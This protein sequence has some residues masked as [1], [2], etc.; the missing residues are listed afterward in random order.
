MNYDVFPRRNL[1]PEA[2]E[3]GRT[4]EDR[5]YQAE[6]RSATSDQSLSGL[7]RSSAA[8][9]ENLAEQINRVEALYRAI[10]KATQQT[11]VET[12]FAVPGTGTWNTIASVSFTYPEPGT[13]SLS[14]IASGQL[15]SPSTSTLMGCN[16]RIVATGLPPS[17]VAPGLYATPGGTWVNN[18][19]LSWGWAIPISGSSAVTVSLQANPQD[20]ASWGGGTGSYAVLSVFG[21][22]TGN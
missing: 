19:M 22:F 15:I 2:E 20:G 7:N 18:F 14:A 6:N 21:T 17:H 5:V 16:Y 3:W 1:P 11:K 4:V 10:P 8:T 9:L 12:N 13:L